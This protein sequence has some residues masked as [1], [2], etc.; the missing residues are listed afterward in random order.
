MSDHKLKSLKKLLALMKNRQS[1]KMSVYQE[2]AKQSG[3]A[4]YL[5]DMGDASNMELQR[6]KLNKAKP[7][8]RIEKDK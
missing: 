7:Y 8:D 3:M 6:K 4:G 1:K 5:P 2:G